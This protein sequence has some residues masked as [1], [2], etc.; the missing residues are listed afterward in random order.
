MNTYYKI[1][2]AIGMY[3]P[4]LLQL[5]TSTLNAFLFR[6]DNYIFSLNF[7]PLIISFVFIIFFVV[8]CGLENK[9]ENY[10][11]YTASILLSFAIFS[12][13]TV[14]LFYSYDDNNDETK[15][16]NRDLMKYMNI[17][18]II[19]TLI[20]FLYITKLRFGF[21]N[22]NNKIKIYGVTEKASALIS[23]KSQVLF[24]SY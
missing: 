14:K 19:S 1:A 11:F 16:N 4:L 20:C 2:I 8:N 3:A 7:A 5:M 24:P 17:V 13:T 6:N 10:S 18:I 23:P 9:T 15:K 22:S 12:F 21:F